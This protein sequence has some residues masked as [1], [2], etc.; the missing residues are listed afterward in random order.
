MVIYS[1]GLVPEEAWKYS[2]LE[3]LVCLFFFVR[4]ASTD[5]S[6]KPTVIIL[7]SGFHFESEL[8]FS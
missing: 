7:R 3:E 8:W 6:L 2:K 5:R 1:T 4:F